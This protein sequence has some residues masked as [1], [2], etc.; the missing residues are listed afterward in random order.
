MCKGLD[1]QISEKENLGWDGVFLEIILQLLLRLIL[2][3]LYSWNA[4]LF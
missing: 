2:L 4:S 3:T 1:L